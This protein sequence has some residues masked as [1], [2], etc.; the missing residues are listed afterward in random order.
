MHFVRTHESTMHARFHLKSWRGL[1]SVTIS[2]TI[3]ITIS[4]L[5]FYFICKIFTKISESRISMNKVQ[6]WLDSL[7]KFLSKYCNILKVRLTIL[8]HYT[9]NS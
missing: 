1:A 8:G 5:D 2:L 9:V 6:I 4:D 7:L 3:Q